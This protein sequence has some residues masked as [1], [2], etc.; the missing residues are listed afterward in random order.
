[1]K[2]RMIVLIG[3]DGSGKTTQAELL[4]EWLNSKGV[5][6]AAVWMRGESYLTRPLLWIGK[7]VLR[8][9][10]EK[11]RGEGIKVGGEYDRYVNSKESMFK[12]GLLRAIWR[13]LTLIDLYISLKKALSKLPRTAEVIVMDRYVYDTFIDIDSAFGAG[14]AEL[15]RLL[16]SSWLRLFPRPCSVILIEISPEDAMKRKD[17]I[18]S[19][20]YLTERHGL[21]NRVAWAVGATSIDGTQSVEEVRAELTGMVEG[22]IG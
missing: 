19:M 6:A 9:P 11:K 1:M 13:V 14:G 18:P 7:A 20:R 22:A 15:D 3:L 8:A 5:T 2:R 10:G 16:K 21:Y 17:D 4:C 12:S